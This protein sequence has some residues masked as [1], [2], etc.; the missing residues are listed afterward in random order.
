[1]SVVLPAPVW[2]TTATVSPGSM[3]EAHVPQHPVLVLVGEPDVVELDARGAR[4]GRGRGRGA[5]IARLGVSSSLKMRSEDA[6]ADCRMLYFSLRSWMGRKKRSPYWKKATTTPS[7]SAPR[8]NAEAAVGEDARQRQHGEELHHRVE[9]AVGDDGVLV[10]VHVVAVDAL[11][12]LGALPLPVEELQHHDA[13]DVLLQVGVDAGDG[14]ADAAVAL[15]HAAA[16][17]HGRQHHER[18]HRQHAAA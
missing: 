6:M 11:E 7:V 10:R 4:R 17:Q 9:P 8:A 3:R 16:E 12:L 5:A 13:G 1:M 15:R 14:D 18:H 2:P